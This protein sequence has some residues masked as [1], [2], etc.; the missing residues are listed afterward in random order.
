MKSSQDTLTDLNELT[1]AEQ[2]Q[3]LATKQ[4][5]MSMHQSAEWGMRLFQMSFPWLKDTVLFEEQGERR[6]IFMIILLLFNLRA[7][8]VGI[9]QI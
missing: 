8:L 2:V 3:D 7:Q 6:N 5:A 4:V 9:D 1:Y